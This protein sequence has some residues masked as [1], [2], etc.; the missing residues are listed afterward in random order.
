YSV[1][2]CPRARSPSVS[3]ETS[4]S[5]DSPSPGRTADATGATCAMRSAPLSLLKRPPGEQ[6]VDRGVVIGHVHLAAVEERVQAVGVQELCVRARFD[7]PA[8]V[9]DE[10]LGRA[11]DR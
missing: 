7:D 6:L 10:D 2:S 8:F 11:A 4:C 5:T 1:T 3:S 9:D